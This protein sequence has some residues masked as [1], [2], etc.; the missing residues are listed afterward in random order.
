MFIALYHIIANLALP[1][2]GNLHEFAI[3]IAICIIA[4]IAIRIGLEL[5]GVHTSGKTGGLVVGAIVD[6]ILY[7]F[8][9]V[10][11]AIGWVVRKTV[12]ATPKIYN[13]S[14]S[15]YM[16][17]GLNDV[18]STALAILTASAFVAIII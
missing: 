1:K 15:F 17:R 7:L 18:V 11:E 4:I 13:N 5:V 8:K 12:E 14:K 2:V 3:T 9:K 10:V 16:K 6:A